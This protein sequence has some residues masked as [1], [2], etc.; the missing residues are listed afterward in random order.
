MFATSIRNPTDAVEQRDIRSATRPFKHD[1]D[2]REKWSNGQRPAAGVKINFN[3]E[4]LNGSEVVQKVKVRP[5][6]QWSQMYVPPPSPLQASFLTT[7]HSSSDHKSHANKTPKP[8]G[9]YDHARLAHKA[10]ALID[11]NDHTNSS[12]SRSLLDLLPEHTQQ[13]QSTIKIA[14]RESAIAAESGVLYSFDNKGPSPGDKGRK[15][16]LGGLVELAEQKFISQQTEK[17][18]KSEYELIDREGE[19]EVLKKKGKRSPKQRATKA[20]P[21]VE[22]AVEED[23]GFTLV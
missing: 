10:D 7:T 23:D 8:F 16:D 9:H 14:L 19:K 20:V 12:L 13:P 11:V 2:Q 5:M 6:K 22:D 3:D 1:K 4:A 21:V 17:I 18:V 15:V